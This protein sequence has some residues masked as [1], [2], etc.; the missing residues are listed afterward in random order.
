MANVNIFSR[1]FC[2]LALLSL[3]TAEDTFKLYETEKEVPRNV[4]DLWANYDPTKE[5]LDTEIIKIWKEEGVICKYVL[6]TVGTFKGVPARIA[7]FYTYP[8]GGSKLP[9]FVW[10][11]GGGQNA[12]K[13]RGYHFAKKGYATVDINWGG[14]EI[15]EG[16]TKNTDWGNIDPSQGKKFYAQSKRGWKVTLSPDDYSVDKVTSPRN[17]N[18]FLLAVTG[19]R[20]ITFLEKQ[21]EVD[22]DKLGFT[23]FSM[24]GNITNMSA[25]DP[26]L[27]A[28]IP[29]VGGSGHR[30][31][32]YLG[33]P[34]SARGGFTPVELHKP[35]IEGQYYWEKVQCPVMFLSSSND[36]HG[37]FDRYYQCAEALPHDNWR[38]T[39]TLHN[40]HSP[41]AKQ[42]LAA[43]YWFDHYLKGKPLA[44]AT[45]ATS[46]L[47]KTA[48]GNEAVFTVTPDQVNNV[49]EV[50]IYSSYNSFPNL[51]FNKNIPA[52]RQGTSWS[53]T[54]KTRKGLP[55][56]VFAEV[57]YQSLSGENEVTLRGDTDTFS[58]VSQQ[59]ILLPQQ[60]DM[61]QLDVKNRTFE[62][63]FENFKNGLADWGKKLR[64]D[65]FSFLTY[66]FNAL[67]LSFPA[68]KK[69]TFKINNPKGKK[70]RM[71]LDITS[72]KHLNPKQNQARNLRLTEDISSGKALELSYSLT[73]FKDKEKQSP[74]TSWHNISTL[75]LFLKDLETGKDL[76]LSLPQNTD[77]IELIHWTE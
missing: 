70:L 41:R 20:A 50:K 52:T 4:T 65:N 66:K 77:Y 22:P 45:T 13:K 19:R 9:A 59:Q 32:D 60:L 48:S 16:I 36:F 43:E 14:R 28:V 72:K 1:Y 29:M 44:I 17:S 26:R 18:W 6:F 40:D 5:P 10:A 64:N 73:D 47:K 21:P 35:T 69:L 39:Q 55:L 3:V 24:G 34:G 27:K 33:H 42:F 31:Q 12:D 75:T 61:T 54:I 67:D 58:I 71:Y 49:K 74:I 68:D 23:G 15:T 11:H 53:A 30:L 38:I 46:T 63:I 37:V 76:D 57:T 2:S 51:R 7:A 62:P 56:Y 25:I 8:E